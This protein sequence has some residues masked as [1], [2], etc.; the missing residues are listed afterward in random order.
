MTGARLAFGGSFLFC[1]LAFGQTHK[2]M[3]IVDL[4]GV[5]QIHD[6]QLSRDGSQVVFELAEA[7]WDKNERVSHIWR[8]DI[9]GSDQI[10]LTTG[11]TGE[12]SPRW[13]PDGSSVV[14]VAKRGKDEHEQLYLLSNRG[15]EARPLTRH[16]SAVKSPA[17]S[18]DGAFVY[19]LAP[20]PKSEEERK[21]DELK[22]DVF[23]YDEDYKQV[24]LF[25]VPVA[26]GAPAEANR[27]TSGDFSIGAYR[28][29]R[30]G[31]RVAH[32]RAPT[33]LY[34]S[35]GESMGREYVWE[36]A[37]AKEAKDEKPKPTED[38]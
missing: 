27:I 26:G 28:L 11:A 30:D 15:G 35:A 12:K 2:T 29:S 23:S 25:R 16:P 17:F 19:F 32:H 37:P 18:P 33:P 22:D 6:V 1:G 34:G 13:S 20:E 7:D 8:V 5:P 14:F 9:D 38:P 24:H 31:F 10:Q 21:K 3:S 36:T 4:I